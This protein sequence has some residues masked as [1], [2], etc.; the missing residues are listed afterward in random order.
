MEAAAVE[1][2]VAVEVAAL[3]SSP[4]GSS[5]GVCGVVVGPAGLDVGCGGAAG[6]TETVGSGA[7]RDGGAGVGAGPVGCVTTGAGGAATTGAV[8]VLPPASSTSWRLPPRAAATAFS[9]RLAR[10]CTIPIQLPA[11]CTTAR[12]AS[13]RTS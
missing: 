2:A 8:I 11:T 4:D 13:R 9:S 3:R 1:V 10:L 6:L 5:G 7:G 12:L